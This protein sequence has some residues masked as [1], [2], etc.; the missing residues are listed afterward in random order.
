MKTETQKYAERGRKRARGE[1]VIGKFFEQV[2]LL[3]DRGVAREWLDTKDF[4][5]YL[6]DTVILCDKEG[7]FRYKDESYVYKFDMSFI[8]RLCQSLTEDI[9][10]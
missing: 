7:S 6:E 2:F 4:H 9:E 5:I 10:W 3:H 8:N 1:Y